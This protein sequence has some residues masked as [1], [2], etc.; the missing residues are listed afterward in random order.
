MTEEEYKPISV[1]INEWEWLQVLDI[2]GQT[3]T[4]EAGKLY[5]AI[6]SQVLR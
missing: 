4:E 2:L 6:G 1:R 5:Q 3:D